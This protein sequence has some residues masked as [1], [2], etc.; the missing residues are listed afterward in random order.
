MRG[1]FY[2]CY[3]HY[4]ISVVHAHSDSASIFKLKHIKLLLLA[5]FRCEDHLQFAIAYS[6]ILHRITAALADERARYEKQFE[7]VSHF[8]LQ[9]QS[10]QQSAALNVWDIA[11]YLFIPE[12][13][14][15]GILHIQQEGGLFRMNTG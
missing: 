11:N 12:T 8:T 13:F 2:C 7:A 1:D 3:C 6:Q 15:E 5:I 4:L 9:I 14:C 10:M